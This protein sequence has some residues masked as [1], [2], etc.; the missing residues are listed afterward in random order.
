[1]RRLSQNDKY[2][3]LGDNIDVMV[4]WTKKAECRNSGQPKGCK[5]TERTKNDMI[6][7]IKLA[8]GKF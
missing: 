4:V 7:R 2:N 1:M 3:D 6:G 8:I 5:L